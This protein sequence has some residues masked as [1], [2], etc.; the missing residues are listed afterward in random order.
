MLNPK[1]GRFN[2]RKVNVDG[3]TYECALAYMIR[4]EKSDFTDATQLRKLSKVVSLK[5]EQFK[6]R[7]GYVVGLK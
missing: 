6:A 4:L 5:P 1:T 3:E 7:F 2:V